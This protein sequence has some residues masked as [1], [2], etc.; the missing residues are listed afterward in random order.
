M[1][2]YEQTHVA[3]LGQMAEST[4]SDVDDQV[5]ELIMHLRAKA[6]AYAYKASNCVRDFR[7]IYGLKVV[8]P[9]LLQNAVIG[10]FILLN[11]MKSTH[12]RTHHGSPPGSPRF[13]SPEDTRSGFEE[14][15]R[16]LVATGMQCMLSRGIARMVHQTARYLN[17]PLPDAVV[18]MNQAVAE[19]S[20]HPSDVHQLRSSFP[21]WTL[22]RDGRKVTEEYQM[23]DLL[24]KWEELGIREQQ[25]IEESSS[26]G[27][28][29]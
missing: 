8:Q 21:N 28:A 26:E 9:F 22:L 4:T 16:L 23:A 20:W 29:A 7:E 6:L 19:T 13:G 24:K 25:M 2:I 15:F 11:D 18:Q 14:C 5:E 12:P 1:V 27:G 10:S 17:V 3:L